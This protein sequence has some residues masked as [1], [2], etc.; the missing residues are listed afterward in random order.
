MALLALT[1]QFALSFGHLHVGHTAHADLAAAADP[2]PA[3][4]PDTNDHDS[5]YCG[6]YA[7]NALLSGAQ[8]ATPPVIDSLVVLATADVDFDAET[9]RTVPRYSAFHS[10]APPLS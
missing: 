3:A 9:A 8:V 4:M 1:L 7:I 2:R 10:R 5:H 6:I